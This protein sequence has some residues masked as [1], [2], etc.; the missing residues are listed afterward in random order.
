NSID[1]LPPQAARDST[2]TSASVSANS[3]LFMVHPPLCPAPL[4]QNG[5]FAGSDE[6]SRQNVP[7]F[8]GIY[9]LFLPGGVK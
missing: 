6:K 2:S 3:L 8:S 9:C 7:A 5:P 4:F 1:L